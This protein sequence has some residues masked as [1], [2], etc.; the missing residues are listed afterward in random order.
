MNIIADTPE[1]MSDFFNK[2]AASY[3][4]HMKCILEYIEEFYDAVVSC[5]PNTAKCLEVLDLGCGTGIQTLKLLK[6]CPSA[7]VLAIDVSD[8]MLNL[9]SEKLSEYKTNIK[10]KNISIFDYEFPESKYDYII[11]TE[12]MHHFTVAEKLELYKKINRSLKTGGLYLE[13][14]YHFLSQDESDNALRHYKEAAGAKGKY[15]IDIPLLYD[16]Q[17]D[18]L[19]ESFRGLEVL[20]HQNNHYVFCMCK[21]R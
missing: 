14:D 4:D 12:M 2:R 8:E 20:F 1:T 6:K 3:E 19:K 10:T 15:H 5:V 16:E 21:D 9:Y 17:I 18:L 13:A 11:A 7:K